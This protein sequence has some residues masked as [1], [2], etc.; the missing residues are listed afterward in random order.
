MLLKPSNVNE[1][2]HYLSVENGIYQHP[3][4]PSEISDEICEICENGKICI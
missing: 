1:A 4:F 2:L 3:F